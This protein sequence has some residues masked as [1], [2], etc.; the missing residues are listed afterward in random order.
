MAGNN[1]YITD[2][3]I[4]VNDE[5]AIQTIDATLFSG[6]PGETEKKFKYLTMIIDRWKRKMDEV[7]KDPWYLHDKEE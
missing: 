7:A 6:D 3:D 5:E 4:H 1:P 2:N